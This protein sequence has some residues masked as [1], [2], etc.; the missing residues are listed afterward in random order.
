MSADDERNDGHS[1]PSSHPPNV[2]ATEFEIS[3]DGVSEGRKTGLAVA[4]LVLGILE[5]LSA[6]PIFGITAI[7]TGIMALVKMRREPDVHGGRGMAVVGLA[8]ACVGLLCVTPVLISMI[9]PVLSSTRETSRRF[10]CE[11]NVRMIGNALLI[12]QYDNPNQGLP[13]LERLVDLNLIDAQALICP[14]SKSTTPSY[15]LRHVR[16]P[17]AA[18]DVLLF[19]PLENHEGKGGHLLFADGHIRFEQ[20]DNYQEFQSNM[21]SRAP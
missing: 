13:P 15:Q 19:E 1:R 20:N 12:Y 6:I 5:M 17:D 8:C 3:R 11:S 9:R 4:T 7:V 16:G 10:A 18:N 21:K 2:N 14:S